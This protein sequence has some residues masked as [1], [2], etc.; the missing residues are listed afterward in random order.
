MFLFNHK[1]KSKHF[2]IRYE[3]SL[4][5]II[6]LLQ[7]FYADEF[8]VKAKKMKKDNLIELMQEIFLFMRSNEH[9][10]NLGLVNPNI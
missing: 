2:V 8:L 1:W 5:R 9:N 10:F 7:F 4:L 6:A 3:A